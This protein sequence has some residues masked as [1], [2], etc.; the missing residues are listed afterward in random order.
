MNNIAWLSA[1]CGEHLE[2][3]HRWS[4]EAVKRAP[5]N[6]AYLDTAAEAAAD[7]GKWADAVRY[8]STALK[9]TPGDR[10]MTL[11]LKRFEE[12][13]KAAAK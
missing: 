13:L 3:A 10:F 1:R 8:E 12:G 2:E 9:L 6:A 11:Q 4:T 5:S 7:V